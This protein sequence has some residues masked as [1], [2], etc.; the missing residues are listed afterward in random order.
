[1]NWGEDQLLNR[2]LPA[3]QGPGNVL[4]LTLEDEHVTNVFAAFGEKSVTAE[5]VAR[6]AVQHVR[7][8]LASSAAVDEYLA[9]QL[10]VPL[11]LAGGGGFTTARISMHART[12]AEVIERFLPVRFQFGEQGG[13]AVCRVEPSQPLM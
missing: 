12:N 5:A 6:Q 2:G 13:A 8:L 10:M 9:D 3:E 7:D 11:A 1:M 4:L